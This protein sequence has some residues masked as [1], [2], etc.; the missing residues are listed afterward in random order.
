MRHATRNTTINEMMPISRGETVGLC[1]FDGD[2]EEFVGDGEGDGV[3]DS[4]GEGVGDGV[5]EGVG[6]FVGDGVV[7]TGG[8]IGSGA[9]CEHVL[10]PLGSGQR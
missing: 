3:G 6:E 7:H 9:F 1:V 5:G 2:E 10:E 8:A 4:V